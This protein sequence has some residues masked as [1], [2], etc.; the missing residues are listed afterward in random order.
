LAFPCNQFGSQEPQSDANILSF[1]ER[2]YAVKF[3]VF[4][5]IDVNGARSDPLF[6]YLKGAL[7]GTVTNAIKWNFTKFMIVDG[8]PFKRYAT[9]V[10]PADMRADILDILTAPKVEDNDEL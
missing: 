5:K 7:E 3:P 9:T 6:E 10:S 2:K 8:K 4:S 1:V